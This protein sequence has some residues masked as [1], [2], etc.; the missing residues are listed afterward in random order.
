MVF[1]YIRV[2]TDKQDFTG[3]LYSVQ[4]Y[5]DFRQ[6][7]IDEV[8]EEKVSGKV[9]RE[10]RDLGQLVARMKDGD[11][12]LTPEL[13]RLGRSITDTLITLDLLKQKHC[14]VH[15]IKENQISGT[16]EFDMIC[17]VYA[18]ISQTER[19]RI[20][21]R[22]KEALRAKIAQGQK[23]GH[24][25][26]YKCTNVKLTPYSEEITNYLL[27]GKSILFIANKYGVKWIT[28]RNFIR[29]RL[30]WDMSKIESCVRF[31]ETMNAKYGNVMYR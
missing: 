27:Q 23:I 24:Y 20:S 30:K 15:L 28:A 7:K 25:K 13:S 19:E 17:A 6:I 5:A 10:K 3:Q 26:G 11:I 29:D 18:I 12:L 16:K 1:A 31:R 9:P 21:E 22:T 2:S 4:K 8:I 14:T